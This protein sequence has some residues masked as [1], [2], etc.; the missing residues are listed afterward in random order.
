MEALPTSVLTRSLLQEYKE[1][2][3]PTRGKVGD[4]ERAITSIN[5]SMAQARAIFSRQAMELYRDRDLQL[6][7]LSGFMQVMRYKDQR[8]VSFQPISPTALAEMEASAWSLLQPDESRAVVIPETN[9]TDRRLVRARSDLFLAYLMARYLGMRDKEIFEARWDWI[10]RWPDGWRLAIVKRE[11]FRPKYTEGRVPICEELRELIEKHGDRASA[12][13]LPGGSRTA[14]FNA[15]YRDANFWLRRWL[16]DRE[17]GM[18]ELR[19]QAGSEVYTR[20]QS[21]SAAAE[22]LRNKEETCRKHYAK[23]LVPLRPLAMA[24]RS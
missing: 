2:R 23:L 8:D 24:F 12:W 16:P 7:D 21:I 4:Q 1:A 13:I 17:K 15:V 5:S 10:E 9:K 3:F 19:K 22:F 14:R 6:P 11:Y 18:H 20:E